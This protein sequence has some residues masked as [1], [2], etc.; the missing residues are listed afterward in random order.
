[1][2]RTISAASSG[3]TRSSLL[4]PHVRRFMRLACSEA[5]SSRRASLCPLIA[6]RTNKNPANT[7]AAITTE[8]RAA[9][10][11]AALSMIHARTRDHHSGAV[12][13]AKV[14]AGPTPPAFSR[15]SFQSWIVPGTLAAQLAAFAPVRSLRFLLML[16]GT[17]LLSVSQRP[18]V[19]R[20]VSPVMSGDGAGGTWRNACAVT[21]RYP[22]FEAY[23]FRATAQVGSL[24]ELTASMNRLL[25]LL[26]TLGCVEA[27]TLPAIFTALPVVDLDRTT[28]VTET[29]P[30]HPI[31]AVWQIPPTPD[32][33]NRAAEGWG[34]ALI[35]DLGRRPHRIAEGD[36][37]GAEWAFP[38]GD[39]IRSLRVAIHAHDVP[40]HGRPEGQFLTRWRDRLK[41]CPVPL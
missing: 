11:H 28:I 30:L 18:T 6:K 24:V 15:R 39:T 31:H 5:L 37:F 29:I 26:F 27:P 34:R 23:Q 20:P 7:H 13:P 22:T 41:L 8:I 17:S 10:P 21:A 16:H 35:P 14:M 9:S 38:P 3:D 12:L 33:Q 25:P 1:M 2:W 4:T 40:D 36:C 19:G 32:M